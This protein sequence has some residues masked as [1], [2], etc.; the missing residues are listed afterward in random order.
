MARCMS[1]AIMLIDHRGITR[2]ETQLTPGVA[3]CRSQ[4]MMPD[5]FVEGWNAK[6]LETGDKG[7]AL[8]CG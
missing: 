4:G 1:R 6:R 3:L 8:R 7:R 5:G 2:D